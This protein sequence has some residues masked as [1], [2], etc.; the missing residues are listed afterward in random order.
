[1]G[2][3]ILIQRLK[4]QNANAISSSLT[5]GVPSITAF[6][7]F[8]HQLQRL[9]AKQMPDCDFKVTGVGVIVHDVDLQA[10]QFKGSRTRLK[11]TA[12]SRGNRNESKKS[13]RASFIEEGRCHLEVSLLLD[14][15]TEYAGGQE[16]L[17]QTLERLVFGRMRLAGGE[18]INTEPVVVQDVQDD[19]RTLCRL[20][21]GWVLLERRDMM[22]TLMQ[23]A[24]AEGRDALDAM[25]D[26]LAIRHER[27]LESESTEPTEITDPQ[28]P[29][30]AKVRWTSTRLQPGFIVP[31]A[32]G[33]QALS[34]ITPSNN[35]R[36]RDTPHRLAE[37]VLTLGEFVLPIRLDRPSKSLWRYH[38]E[39]DLYTCRQDACEISNEL[40]SPV[41][42]EL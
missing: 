4:V 28:P 3:L 24:V 27:H 10:R 20:I 1:M 22:Q 41:P 9:V 37:S 26:A 6:M 17:M 25:H 35:A 2:K 36:D 33:Y 14:C 18:I 15:E 40:P 11:L 16:R 34:P 7:G 39:G 31:I 23:A 19:R 13:E 30:K 38:V 12:N 21:P 29:S 5:I 8:A 42:G 32:T